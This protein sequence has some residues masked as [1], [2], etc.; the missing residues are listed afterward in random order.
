MAAG[1]CVFRRR[2]SALCRGCALRRRVWR[3]ADGRGRSPAV[4]TRAV[5][6][7]TELNLEPRSVFGGAPCQV[8]GCGAARVAGV[9]CADHYDAT[10]S[11]GLTRRDIRSRSKTSILVTPATKA[12]MKVIFGAFDGFWLS[13]CAW[14]G[15]PR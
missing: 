6:R 13:V 2:W 8:R 12:E 5:S 7:A 1:S 10:F 9:F 11:G 15:G 4:C 3:G 14:L